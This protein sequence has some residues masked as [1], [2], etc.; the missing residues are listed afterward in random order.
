MSLQLLI[1]ALGLCNLSNSQCFACATNVRDVV[2]RKIENEVENSSVVF[3][4][5]TFYS[6]QSHTASIVGYS[7][8]THILK[9]ILCNI[10]ML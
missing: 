5:Y 10:D 2:R 6:T 3:F 1:S 4:F 9:Q 8:H 7:R